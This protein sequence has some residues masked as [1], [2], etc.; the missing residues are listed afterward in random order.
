MI[1]MIYQENIYIVDTNIYFIRKMLPFKNK[2][3]LVTGAGRG[4]GRGISLALAKSGIQ[5]VLS[6]RSGSQLKRVQ[7]EIRADGGLA[8]AIPADVR[9]PNSVKNLFQRIKRKFSR[10]D[11]LIN[12]AGLGLYGEIVT[13]PLKRLDA[14]LQTNL[15]GTF[16]CCQAALRIMIPQKNG[17]IV[18]ISSVVGIKGYPRQSAYTASKHGI[19]GLTK[20]L[21]VE[22]QPFNIRVS[23]VH[24]G[25]VDTDMIRSAR[26]D[27]D[28]KKL[29]QPED[30]A[31]TVIFLLTLSDRA[32]IDEIYIRRRESQPF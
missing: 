30:I 15:R 23:V 9:D 8:F 26:P 2:V 1:N 3:A 32:A 21:A 7:K 14:V 4:I 6:S 25:G 16:L 20:S 19:V 5:V 31:Q 10:L 22:A 13:F 12:N 18:N 11:I 24:P 27:L 28:R 17:Y 29:L